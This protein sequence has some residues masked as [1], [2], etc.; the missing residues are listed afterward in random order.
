M[1]VGLKIQRDGAHFI[2]PALQ[3]RFVDLYGELGGFSFD[4]FL[5]A[6]VFFYAEPCDVEFFNLV[7]DLFLLKVIF[8]CYFESAGQ[9]FAKVRCRLDF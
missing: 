2:S 5:E 4:A 9:L 6:E 7:H 3:H 8:C 1:V